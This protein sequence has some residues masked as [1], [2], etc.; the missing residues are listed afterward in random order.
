MPR[1]QVCFLSLLDEVGLPHEDKKHVYGEQLEIIGLLVDTQALSIL[2]SAEAKEKLVGAIRDFVLNTPDNKCQQSLHSWLRI[3]GCANWA[4]NVFPILK[5][6]LNSSHDKVTGKTVLSQAVYINKEVQNDLLWFADSVLK[7]DGVCLFSAEEWNA[8]EAD[9]QIWCDASKEGL[10]FWI[11]Q[12]ACGFV[13]DAIVEDDLSFNIFFNEALAILAALHWSTSYHPIPT[14][15]AIHTDS[16][17]SFNIFNS[18]HASGPYNT[19][20]MSATSTRIEH[21]ID[22]CVFFIEGKCNVIA[23]ASS[24]QTLDLV[25]KLVPDVTIRHFMPPISPDNSVMGASLK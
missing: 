12:I 16:S 7:L 18:L 25:R 19:I 9:I 20:L 8:D 6:A 13:G 3:L 14:R 5:P 10:A 11:P 15:L 21:G 2:M 1:D 22:L 17:N 23:D 4:L 24:C